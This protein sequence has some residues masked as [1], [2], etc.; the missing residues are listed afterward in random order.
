ML[1]LKP[2][3]FYEGCEK[4]LEVIVDRGCPNLRH[5]G[6]DFWQRVVHCADA[7][8]VSRMSND[9]CDAYVLSESS[10]FVWQDRFVM[11][12]CGETVLAN[13]L[14]LFA[15]EIGQAQIAFVSYQRGKELLPEQQLSHFVDDVAKIKTVING[16]SYRIGEVSQRHHFLFHS[17]K[18]Y[19][20]GSQ[21][22]TSELLMYQIRGHVSNYLRQPQQ[23]NCEILVLLGLKD[24][25]PTFTFDDYLFSP[26]GY[27]LNG[28]S[29]SQYLTLHITPQESGSY[30]GCET[31]LSDAHLVQ[32][33][34]V[35]LL[36]LFDPKTWDV[37]GFNATLNLPRF[38]VESASCCLDIEQGY[39]IEFNYFEASANGRLLIEKL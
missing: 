24:L 11:I 21:D 23:K 19:Q 7:M 20:P 8:I 22:C 39:Q 25:L 5:L 15:K 34:F 38:S 18:Q 27:S 2:P 36:K 13:S 26:L 28:I 31:N 12:T 35:H 1:E 17:H 3:M 32:T 10:L 9:D 16:Q 6:A 4:K 30:V 14:I 37:I 29:G 33:I